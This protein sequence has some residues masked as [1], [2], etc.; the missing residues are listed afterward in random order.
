MEEMGSALT[1]DDFVTKV[2]SDPYPNTTLARDS[3]IVEVVAT[4]SA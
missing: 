1:I 3:A 4:R 2:S